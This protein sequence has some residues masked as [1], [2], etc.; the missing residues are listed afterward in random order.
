MRVSL[1]KDAPVIPGPPIAYPSSLPNTPEASHQH[2]RHH[3]NVT[4][5]VL[6]NFAGPGLQFHSSFT[7]RVSSERC[8]SPI[9][10]LLHCSRRASESHSHHSNP[11]G[12]I[13]FSLPDTTKTSHSALTS[14]ASSVSPQTPPDAHG[15]GLI[16]VASA[17]SSSAGAPIIPHG[18]TLISTSAKPK[19]VAPAVAPSAVPLKNQSS[20][21]VDS[22]TRRRLSGNHLVPINY[23]FLFQC[24]SLTRIFVLLSSFPLFLFSAYARNLVID[25]PCCLLMYVCVYMPN[26]LPYLFLHLFIL[27]FF[28]ELMGLS[29][30]C[31]F[32]GS[33]VLSPYDYYSTI[34]LSFFPIGAVWR[35]VR[36][37]NNSHATM[38]KLV[39][40]I[41]HVTC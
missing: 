37:E 33:G 3:L 5:H 41:G 15:P 30:Y 16:K 39:Y 6:H 31:L 4:S 40:I 22:R 32:M 28:Y 36:P 23:L 34:S 7:T 35:P 25:P 18:H 10:T 11:T 19:T 24:L 9:Y 20:L 1:P 21:T 12:R 17:E 26:F 8:P 14:P 2:R 29:V 13:P 27:P 38:H